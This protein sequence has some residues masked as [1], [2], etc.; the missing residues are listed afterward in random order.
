MYFF[1]GTLSE[2]KGIHHQIQ[3]TAFGADS[4]LFSQQPGPLMA[5]Y[6]NSKLLIAI[7]SLKYLQ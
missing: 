1:S 7:I 3:G 5:G 6:E 2:I 4:H